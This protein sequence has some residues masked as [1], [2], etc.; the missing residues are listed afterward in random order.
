MGLIFA[1]MLFLLLLLFCSSALASDD[2]WRQTRRQTRRRSPRG[3]SPVIVTGSYEPIPLEDRDRSVSAFDVSE[4]ELVTNTLA[5]LLRLDPSL[6]LRSRAPNGVQSDLSIRGG[7]FGQTLVLLDGVRI[8]DAQSGHH[9][10]DIP[11]PLSAVSRLEILRGSGSTLY[12]SDAV[13]GVL[14]I[15]T[16]TPEFS[17]FRLRS[18]VGN[19]G[20]NQQR[21]TLALVR[22]RVAEQISSPGFFLRVQSQPGLPQPFDQLDDGPVVP[23]GRDRSDPGAQ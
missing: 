12:G 17:E 8:N 7:T 18:S 6:D 2:H 4:L 23:A 16:K 1:L 11:V 19:F 10:M 3:T 22:G 21:G 9:N 15:I 20:V 14:N 13:G 5:D